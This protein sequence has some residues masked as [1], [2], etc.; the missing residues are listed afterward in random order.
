M[1]AKKWR[2]D[3][4]PCKNAVISPIT[5]NLRPITSLV[6]YL[7]LKSSK[8]NRQP[9][10]PPST[11]ASR[12]ITLK[13]T[14]RISSIRHPRQPRNHPSNV[15]SRKSRHSTCLIVRKACSSFNNSIPAMIFRCLKTPSSLK[16]ISMRKNKGLK[17][18]PHSMI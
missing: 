16:Y 14:A 11:K 18:G 8:W 3:A 13:R 12:M 6:K 2:F 15:A 7:R 5:R 9:S 10:E 17:A 4:R 1:P